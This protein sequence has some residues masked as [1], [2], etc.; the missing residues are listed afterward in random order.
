MSGETPELITLSI[1]GTTGIIYKIYVEST[2]DLEIKELKKKVSE[3][4]GIPPEVFTL[5]YQGKYLKENLKMSDYEI[6]KSCQINCVENTLGGK[7]K[8]K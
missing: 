7:F 2:E 3:H 8:I 1:V 6:K 4:M 5:I